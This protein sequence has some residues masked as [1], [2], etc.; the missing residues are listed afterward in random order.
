VADVTQS[1]AP[2]PVPH[3]ASLH[4]LARLL[5]EAVRIPG[6]NVR[7]GLDAVLGLIPGA[8]DVAGGLLSAFIIGQAA[9]LGASRAVLAR[10]VLNVAVDAIV[11]A[12]PIVGDLFDIGWK[13]NTRNA[14]L[15]E[16]HVARPQATRRTSR[17]AVVGAVAA[18]AII[19]GGVIAL[20][21]A[22]VRGVAGLAS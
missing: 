7:V 2:A 12:V 1:H 4:Q 10:M 3:A 22:L 15:L 17:L 11:G 6:T 16:Q 20:A 18:V 21:V 5:D 8:G 14:R 19:I 9:A 13:A